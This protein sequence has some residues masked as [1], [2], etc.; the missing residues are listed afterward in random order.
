MCTIYGLQICRTTSCSCVCVSDIIPDSDVRSFVFQGRGRRS[1]PP[2]CSSN[3]RQAGKRESTLLVQLFPP[4]VPYADTC[5]LNIDSE[6]QE[7]GNR[8]RYSRLRVKRQL[9]KRRAFKEKTLERP[10]L[11]TR[12]LANKTPR[13]LQK[14]QTRAY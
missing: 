3:L 10:S 6:V 14:S 5:N 13:L 4:H 11:I 1:P 9:L 12:G 8:D 7:G 2:S